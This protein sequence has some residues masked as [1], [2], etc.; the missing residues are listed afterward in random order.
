MI[1]KKKMTKLLNNEYRRS[2]ISS[3]SHYKLQKYNLIAYS[4]YV[5]DSQIVHRDKSLENDKNAY[6][7]FS[8][9]NIIC[10]ILND[11]TIIKKFIEFNIIN[12]FLHERDGNSACEVLQCILI[13][14]IKDNKNIKNF[15]IELIDAELEKIEKDYIK[16]QKIQNTNS[17]KE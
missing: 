10:A 8:P 7:G 6:Y 4:R 3:I 16:E 11:G 17:D 9:I 12:H 13:D 5:I 15:D 2:I 1:T 14:W